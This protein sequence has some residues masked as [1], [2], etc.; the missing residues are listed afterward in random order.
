MRRRLV[1]LALA[2]A[3]LSVLSALAL[4]WLAR[5]ALA[6]VGERSLAVAP[7]LAR[8]AALTGDTTDVELNG[9]QL[10]L[11]T[12]TVEQPPREVLA[13]FEALCARA[14]AQLTADLRAMQ[15][16]VP[17]PAEEPYLGVLKQEYG[18]HGGIGACV[19]QGPDGGGLRG[20][21]AQF[22]AFADERDLSVFGQLRYL[23]A[24]RTESGGTH[25]V[26][27]WTRGSL[28]LDEMLPAEGD[29]A[30]G[31]LRG[32]PRPTGGTRLISAQAHGRSYG[33]V[34]YT[35]KESPERAMASYVE[36]LEAEGIKTLRVA[37]DTGA[38]TQLR[39][40]VQDEEPLVVQ[41][42]ARGDE[43]LVSVV[44]LGGRLVNRAVGIR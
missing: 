36:L 16:E 26:M 30:G 1:R 43:T 8:W 38:S 14:S 11:S 18:E 32:V 19:A 25:A 29:A 27:V 12:L 17:A 34:A 9:Q 5:G 44:K 22:R 2:S 33:M 28:K 35:V 15:G 6:E 39:G 10:S 20:L 4:V 41:T 42:F 7:E 31:D 24:R 40:A 37:P 21:R 3:L 23:I 13:R